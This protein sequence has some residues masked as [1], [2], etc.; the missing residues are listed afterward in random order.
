MLHHPYKLYDNQDLLSNNHDHN[1][2]NWI[3]PTRIRIFDRIVQSIRIP[4]IPLHPGRDN[5]IGGG[6]PSQRRVGDALFLEL[7]QPLRLLRFISGKRHLQSADSVGE[8]TDGLCISVH[9]V[10][11]VFGLRDK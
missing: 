4:I 1:N 5:G 9:N 3:M 2:C 10:D 11:E 7:H 8:G 6:K